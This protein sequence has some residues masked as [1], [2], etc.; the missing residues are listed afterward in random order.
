M[1]ITNHHEEKTLSCDKSFMVQGRSTRPKEGVT[2]LIAI[3]PTRGCFQKI[4]RSITFPGSV[5]A[6]AVCFGCI[7][8]AWFARLSI[9][10][11]A[12]TRDVE[13]GLISERR[14]LSI[15][16]L[17][18]SGVSK[19]EVGVPVKK[20]IYLKRAMKSLISLSFKKIPGE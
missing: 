3:E 5:F 18:F 11:C 4:S 15:V 10:L 12:K 19:Y 6:M 20:P 14:R 9:T 1:G 13:V 8:G 2:E 17:A 16:F 7:P